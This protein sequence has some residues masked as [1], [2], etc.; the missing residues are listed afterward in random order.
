MN[1]RFYA[2]LFILSVVLL[3]GIATQESV[4]GYMDA[5]Y[6]YATGLRLAT[7][8]LWSEPFIWNYLGEPQGL[9]QPAFTYW[10][11]M[12]GIISALGIKLGG[13]N[14]FW[15]ARIG[16]LLIASCLAPLTAYLAFSFTPQRWAGILAGTIAVFSSF[17][18]A[19]LPTTETFGIYML[20]GSIFFLLVKKMQRDIKDINPESEY[21]SNYRQ[22]VKGEKLISPVWVYLLSGVVSGLMYMTRVDGLIWMGMVIAAILL[23]W[24]SWKKIDLGGKGKKGDSLQ[25]WFALILFLASFL[26]ITSPWMIRNLLNFGS[27]FAPGSGRALWLTG[28]DELFT[29]PA[30]QLTFKRWLDSGITEIIRARGWALGLN[31]MTAVAVQGGIFL[32][33]L[34][35]SGLW[36]QRKEWCVLVGSGGWLANFLIMTLVFPFQGARGGFFHAGAGFQPLFW[37]L[38][39]TGLLA[40]INWGSRRRN[41]N[42]R[43]ALNVFVVGII[44]F[45]IIMTAFLTWQRIIG[46]NRS[47]SVWGKAALAYPGVESFLDALAVPSEAIVM[48]NNPPGYF[49]MTG[50]RAIVIPDGDLQS[51]LRA[52]RDFEASYLILDENHPAGLSGVYQHPG[53]YPGLRYVDTIEQ[54]QI[55]LLE[56]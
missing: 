27:I 53:D 51:S 44:G 18:F 29:Y 14:S 49:A 40:F 36:L 56:Q 34:I 2:A 13:W 25:L 37:A 12:A 4:P 5:D 7:Q 54:M 33:P 35:L 17:Y 42:S 52:G 19:Y 8:N 24:S 47:E 38:V 6:Y 1:A 15:S 11:P 41:W 46:S 21:I 23:Q 48:V 16:F 43:Q 10:M 39:P 32:V 31:I 9:P 55:Y 22:S 50:R 3:V 30:A 45:V 20:L 26:L 28:Y